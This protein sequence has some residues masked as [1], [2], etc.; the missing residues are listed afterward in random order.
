MED[1]VTL[2]VPSFSFLLLSLLL[3]LFGSRLSTNRVGMGFDHLRR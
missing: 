1:G 2:D 3:F